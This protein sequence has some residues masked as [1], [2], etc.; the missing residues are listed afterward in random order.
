MPTHTHSEL[1]RSSAHP[2]WV[3]CSARTL[4]SLHPD[5]KF[6]QEHCCPFILMGSFSKNIV[7]PSSCSLGSAFGVCEM[8]SSWRCSVSPPWPSRTL[9]S[10][11]PAVL[12][13]GWEAV[14]GGACS[15][16]PPWVPLTLRAVCH[17]REVPARSFMLDGSLLLL[18]GGGFF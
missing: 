14:R 2:A 18:G 7:V 4:L 15:V 16:P 9:L 3:D 12:C 6:Q 17:C 5:G 11:H 8:G 1:C 10:L 13:V